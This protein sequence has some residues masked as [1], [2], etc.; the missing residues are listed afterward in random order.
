MR[1]LGGVRFSSSG[2][3]L[4]YESHESLRGCG[5]CRTIFSAA[6]HSTVFALTSPLKMFVSFCIFA[7]SFISMSAPGVVHPVVHSNSTSE[8][9]GW[10]PRM[11]HYDLDELYEI[12]HFFNSLLA[13]LLALYVSRAVTRWW[14]MRNSCVGALWDS[15]DTLCMWA[16]AWWSAAT[17]ADKTSRALVL[18]YGLLS[19]ALLFKQ[20]RGEL[21]QANS[22]ADAGLADLVALKLLREH[23]AKK[24]APLAGKPHVVWA[25]QARFWTL[26]MSQPDKTSTANKST[27]GRSQPALSKVPNAEHLS[28]IVMS[29]CARGR[30]AISV[31]LTYVA[32]QQ[33]FAYVHMLALSAWIA[34]LLNALLAGLKLAYLDPK[35][36]GGGWHW[37]QP[38]SWPLVLACVTRLLFLPVMYDGLLGL[39]LA[40]ENPF[41]VSGF[42]SE[43][44]EHDIH[45]ECSAMCK[46]VDAIDPAIWW[47]STGVRSL[48]GDLCEKPSP[49]STEA[50]GE[51]CEDLQRADEEWCF[52]PQANVGRFR[53][54][55]RTVARLGSL[56]R[57]ATAGRLKGELDVRRVSPQPEPNGVSCAPSILRSGS[58]AQQ[59]FS[60]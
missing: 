55:V 4:G 14:D 36:L 20:A 46:G 27:E 44:Y 30:D 58:P 60:S 42:P 41:L 25:W 53:R 51:S 34:V 1:T 33:P 32:T 59:H 15:I 29:T 49:D 6:V 10:N 12:Y 5:P 23:E 16:A 3:Q 26:A 50:L 52:G 17:V 8:E 19:H 37:P 39:A 45:S 28:P 47:P 13:F 24:L 18:R 9:T 48:G 40:L 57:L 35:L 43:L 2:I 22:V 21:R 31:G 54:R 38:A 11:D 56:N 7:A